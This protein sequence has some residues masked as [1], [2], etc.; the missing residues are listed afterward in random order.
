MALPNMNAISTTADAF[1][2]F[3]HEPSQSSLPKSPIR[4]TRKLERTMIIATTLVLGLLP[5]VS[6]LSTVVFGPQSRELLLLTA[7]IAA[8]E[9]IITSCICSEGTE[10]GCRRL[11][12]G[13]EYADIGVDESDKARPI[14]AGTDIGNALEAC[15]SITLINYDTP[16]E[17]S[18]LNTLIQNAGPN[19][20]K[21][22]VLAKMGI[23]RAKGGFFGGSDSTLMEAEN[24]IRKV[25]AEKKLALSIVRA[26]VLK[27][28]GPGSDG[29]DFGMNKVYYN[30]IFDIVEANVAMA[31]DKFSIG[32]EVE[33]GDPVDLPNILS[34]MATKSSF[35]PKRGETNRIVAAGATVAALLHPDPVEVS[36]S[37]IKSDQLP[38]MLEW[39][40]LFSKI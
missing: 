5:V 28:G 33:A 3:S 36:I 35:E 8:R 2:R 19:L 31:H 22:V 30:T 39:K 34:Q 9:G 21:I 16:V 13:M 1:S 10:I 27:G 20:S 40:K 14:S 6:S 29:N 7:K 24:R 11:M 38:T 26:G 15:H 17:Q 23:T 12:Y 32:A 18:L 37:S 4:T 25:C